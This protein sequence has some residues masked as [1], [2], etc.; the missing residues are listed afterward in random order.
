MSDLRQSPE[1]WNASLPAS[2]FASVRIGGTAG[3]L[4]RR[5]QGIDPLIEQPALDHHYLTVHLGGAKRVARRSGICV[6]EADMPD[7]RLSLTVAGE[8]YSWSTVGPVDFA[9]LY[10][11]GRALADLSAGA[12]ARDTRPVSLRGRLGFEDPLLRELALGMM[13]AAPAAEPAERVRLDTLLLSFVLTLCLHC[14]DAA[15]GLVTTR[16]RL[17]P[18]RLRRVTD[19]VNAHLDRPLGLAD[20][21]SVAGC[22][23][24]HFSRAFAGETGLPPYAFLLR[25]RVERARLLL[26]EGQLSLVE[27]AA[28]CGY[29]TPARLGRMLR[30][31]TGRT[32]RDHCKGG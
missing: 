5:W 7:G 14:A 19:F 3:A 24:Y 16:H 17:P 2:S 6:E 20:L 18:A 11:S 26:A 8:R 21:A 23:Q 12:L 31:E 22:S 4:I 32:L 28:A 30:R 15:A 10:L 27:I 13:S 25:R 9:H 1:R 29:A